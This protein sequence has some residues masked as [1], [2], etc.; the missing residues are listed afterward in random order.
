M[1]PTYYN[2]QLFFA[3]RFIDKTKI[4]QNEVIIFHSHNRL[5]ND[6]YIKRVIATPGSTVQ[7][8]NGIIYINGHQYIEKAKY[9]TMSE[10]GLAARKIVLKKNEYFVLGDNRN[11]SL[12]SRYLGP[13]QIKDIVGV[14]KK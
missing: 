9:P 7:I 14:V 3:N 8:K 4:K 12:D 11:N 1:F 13:I 6:I 10:Y 5:F 2:G